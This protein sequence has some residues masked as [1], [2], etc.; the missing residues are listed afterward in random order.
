MEKTDEALK[1]VKGQL[2]TEKLKNTAADVGSTIIEGIG[3][4]IGT[5]KVKRQQQ[6]I[7]NLKEVKDVLI[8]EVKTLKQN[9]QIMQKEHETALDK[10]K[11]ELKKIHDLF[12]QFKELLWIEKLLKVM[13]FSED[14]IKEILKMKPIGFKG[15]IYSTEFQRSFKTEYSVAEVKQHP[16][17]KN[18][19]QLTIDGVSET[20]WFRQKYQE[21]QKRIET[22]AQ[23]K[24]DK[25]RGMRM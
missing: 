5:S 2:K 21:F 3:S 17:E 13:R 4:V 7:D 19:L 23:P 20:N 10:L 14:L 1:Q 12:P 11:Q 25:N 18:K 9:T 8:Q 24:Q 22:N 15:R 16:T 6:E